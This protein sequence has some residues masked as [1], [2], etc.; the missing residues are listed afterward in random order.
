[1]FRYVCPN[2]FRTFIDSPQEDKFCWKCGEKLEL[3]GMKKKDK[4]PFEH[5][6]HLVTLAAF[7]YALGRSTYI[8]S[9]MVQ[10]IME[11]WKYIQPET[12]QI[13]IEET[14]AAIK[15][16]SCGEECDQKEW[17]RLLEFMNKKSKII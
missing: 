1:M 5:S 15:I 14:E 8:V 9:E 6:H 16:G 13:I 7:R 2:C 3:V 11:N 4:N 12:K 10:W 17:E